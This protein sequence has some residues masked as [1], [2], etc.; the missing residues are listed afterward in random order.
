MLWKYSLDRNDIPE[1]ILRNDAVQIF[2]SCAAA[3]VKPNLSNRSTSISSESELCQRLNTKNQ[4]YGKEW[5]SVWKARCSFWRNAQSDRRFSQIK[6]C[7]HHQATFQSCSG[8]PISTLVTSHNFLLRV[9]EILNVHFYN[10][11]A[12]YLSVI[13]QFPLTLLLFDHPSP[14]NDPTIQ[15]YWVLVSPLS[16]EVSAANRPIASLSK[17]RGV[18]MPFRLVGWS[19]MRKLT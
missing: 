9:Q 19:E 6:T 4:K 2:C 7:C 1:F 11:M 10:P 18:Q 15:A 8:P 17:K 3:K 12:T 16:L 13:V 14:Q 5:N